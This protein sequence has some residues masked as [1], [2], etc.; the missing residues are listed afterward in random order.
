MKSRFIYRVMVHS[1]TLI[2]ALALSPHP[3]GGFYKEIYKSPQSFGERSLCTTILYLLTRESHIGHLHKNVSDITHYFHW[4]NPIRYTTISPEG[5]LDNFILGPRFDQGEY[6][7]K[8]VMGEYWKASELQGG[9]CD[10]ALISESVSPGFSW[11]EMELASKEMF[12]NLFP[13]LL[14]EV[15]H[16]IL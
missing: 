10:F 3:E 6:F 7:Q 9:N 13:R 15:S 1:K 4:G 12:K 8:T 5:R 16:L 11:D 14:S 2:N